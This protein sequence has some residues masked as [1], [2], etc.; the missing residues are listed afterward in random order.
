MILLKVTKNKALPSL[1]NT[2]LE[3]PE[4]VGQINQLTAPRLSR[5]KYFLPMF[6]LTFPFLYINKNYSKFLKTKILYL[7]QCKG[8]FERFQAILKNFK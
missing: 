3:K 6:D 8:F 1:E 2:I 5:A 4:G 7:K